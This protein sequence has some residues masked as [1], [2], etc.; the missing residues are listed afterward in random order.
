MKGGSIRAVLRLTAKDLRRWARDPLQLGLWAAIPLA[1]AIIMK[2]AF[3]GG[4]GGVRVRLAIAD[5]DQTFVSQL[6]RGAFSQGRLGDLFETTVADSAEAWNLTREGK[7]S[8]AL[9]IPDGFTD[10]YLGGRGAHLALVRN[11]AEHILP[12]IALETVE[13]LA[14]GA[15][16]LR[17]LFG[18]PLAGVRDAVAAKGAP[19]DSTVLG[20]SHALSAVL[21]RAGG[22]FFPPV[23][24][25]E[26][27]DPEA[28]RGNGAAGGNVGGAPTVDYFVLFFPGIVLMA[29]L[30]IAQALAS[31]V[32]EESRL[33]A[34]ARLM[35]SANG[36]RGW[37]LAKLL[38]GTVVFLVVFEIL[39]LAGK[40][41]LRIELGP[42]HAAAG[43]LSLAGSA[44]LGAF[45][46]IAVL[47]RTEKGASLLQTLLVMPLIL[48]GGS[49]FPLESMP[50]AL[51]AVG[52]A[53]PNGMVLAVAKSILL[54]TAET[55]KVLGSLGLC[56][57]LGMLF[58]LLAAR[59]ARRRFVGE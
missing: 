8:A 36:T 27:W 9:F 12:G 58:A 39:F 59:Q 32:W 7:V 47:A 24:A 55:G 38:A 48:L 33:G 21:E 49:L 34:Y 35:T 17:S 22:S 40:Y 16:V 20:V 42:I 4:D 28:A 29:M 18:V 43:Y 26:D 54:G 19:A 23:L 44:F 53:T 2:L 56:L 1:I 51:R 41:L 14:D 10:D 31:D 6:L 57:G 3:G 13:V 15:T 52:E 45:F 5:Q 11:P 37:L 30:F 46:W 50:P 25:L